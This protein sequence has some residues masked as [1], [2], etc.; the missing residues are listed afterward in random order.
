MS[1]MPCESIS[2]MR[3]AGN[4]HSM[5]V[6]LLRRARVEDT[7]EGLT[8]QRLSLL[9]ILVFS[10]PKTVNQLAELE[11]VSAPAISRLVK[12][13]H[14]DGLVLRARS[15]QDNRV[16]FVSATRRA[17]QLLQ[18]AQARRLSRIEQELA[19]LDDS[20]IATLNQAVQWLL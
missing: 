3:V 16:V 4:L 12:Q 9:S 10:G 5:S 17:R 7:K 2:R 11:L 1:N 6:R 20:Q 19:Q 13:L 14:I 15:K 18:A 8:P